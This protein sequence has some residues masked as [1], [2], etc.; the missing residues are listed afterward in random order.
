MDDDE[1]IATLTKVKGIG[2]WTAEMYLIFVLNRP[3]IFSAGDVGLQ[4]AIER[5]Y[6]VG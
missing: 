3:D 4:R 1:V 5:K 6:G 2:Q